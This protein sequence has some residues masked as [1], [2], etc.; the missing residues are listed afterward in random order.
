[1]G[2]ELKGHSMVHVELRCSRELGYEIIWLGE[3]E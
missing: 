3:S 1:M 2:D